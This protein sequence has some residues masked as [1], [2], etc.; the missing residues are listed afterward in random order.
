[1]TTGSLLFCVRAV[2]GK[3][4]EATMKNRVMDEMTNGMLYVFAIEACWLVGFREK[5]INWEEFGEAYKKY[6]LHCK[7]EIHLL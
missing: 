7:V 4:I 2:W 1:M 5:N 6:C 3:R